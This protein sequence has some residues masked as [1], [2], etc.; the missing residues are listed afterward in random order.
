MNSTFEMVR[1]IV[2]GTDRVVNKKLLVYKRDSAGAA[3]L[4]VVEVD[5]VGVTKVGGESEV[6]I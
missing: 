4:V 3:A 1:V 2:M 6:V 5:K